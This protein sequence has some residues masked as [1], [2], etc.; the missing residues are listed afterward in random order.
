MYIRKHLHKREPRSV[1]DCMD[2]VPKYTGANKEG[3]VSL[4]FQQYDLISPTHHPSK[5]R[6]AQIP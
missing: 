2:N 4:Q 1:V 3:Q 6:V 5:L